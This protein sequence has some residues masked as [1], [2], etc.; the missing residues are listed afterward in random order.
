MKRGSNAAEKRRQS[1]LVERITN[2][3]AEIL[4]NLSLEERKRN[5]SEYYL[6]YGNDFVVALKNKLK[7]LQLEFFVLVK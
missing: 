6:E 4:P 2:I 7:P 3:Q 1:D 5:F